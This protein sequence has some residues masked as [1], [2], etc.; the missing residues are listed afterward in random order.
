MSALAWHGDTHP[1]FADRE[2]LES[3][4]RVFRR[5]AATATSREV[6]P[7]ASESIE[8]EVH[9]VSR[10]WATGL[11][12]RVAELA[13]L[14]DNWDSYGGSRMKQEP[15]QRLLDMLVKLGPYIQSE[16]SVSLTGA[17]GLNCEWR[18]QDAH[19]ALQIDPASDPEI[20]FCNSSA[21]MEWEG[22]A[23]HCSLLKRW[24]WQASSTF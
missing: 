17:G 7:A 19:L 4:R 24:L 8:D 18:S 3:G 11:F 20:Y 1:T 6:F 16:P 14:P 10:Q 15:A 13:Q 21:G 12:E 22:S 5:S 9:S 2:R 23:S